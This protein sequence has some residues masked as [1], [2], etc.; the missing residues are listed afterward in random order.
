VLEAVDLFVDALSSWYL[1]EEAATR[2]RELGDPR[3]VSA[4]A[5]LLER[6]PSDRVGEAILEALTKIGTPEATEVVA[7]WRRRGITLPPD[8]T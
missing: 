1:S 5:A 3:A 7:D 2:A 8:Q 4:L 6:M